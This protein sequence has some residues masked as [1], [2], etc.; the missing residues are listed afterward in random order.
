M[1]TQ[2]DNLYLSFIDGWVR[3]CLNL[4]MCTHIYLVILYKIKD[5]MRYTY[6]KIFYIKG[7]VNE[8]PLST[9]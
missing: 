8:C 1:S 9:L 5:M 4:Y 6:E 3:V 2:M 7:L